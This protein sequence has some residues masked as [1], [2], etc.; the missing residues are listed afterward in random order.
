LDFGGGPADHRAVCF[1][2]TL[3]QKCSDFVVRYNRG[4]I[5]VALYARVS[6]TVLQAGEDKVSIPSQISDSRAKV[7]EA[8]G[9]QVHFLDPYVDDKSYRAGQRM[10]EPSGER[11]DRPAFLRLIADGYSGQYDY[12]GAW[13]EDR[14]YRGVKAA[15]PFGEMLEK[16]GVRVILARE[17]FDM[18]MLYLKAAIGKIELDSIRERTRMGQRGRAQKGLHHGASLTAG[19]EALKDDSG[20]TS[21]RILPEWQTW[22]AGLAEAFLQKLSYHAMTVA[23]PTSPDGQACHWQRL[24]RYVR[25]PFYRGYVRYRGELIPGRQPKMW[26]DAVCVQIETELERRK[27]AYPYTVRMRGQA[28]FTGILRCGLCGEPMIVESNRPNKNHT[29]SYRSYGCATYRRGQPH[30]PNM[31]GEKRVLKLLRMMLS[32]VTADEMYAFIMA[33]GEE[34]PAFVRQRLDQLREELA[35]VEG[36]IDAISSDLERVVSM[37]T[38]KLLDGSLATEQAS[39][40]TLRQ[41]IRDYEAGNN[42][43]ADQIVAQAMRLTGDEAVWDL[44]PPEL[45]QIISEAVPTIYAREGKISLVMGDEEMYVG[46]GRLRPVH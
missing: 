42:L 37:T 46:D 25:N 33:M 45:R 29:G 39:A 21:Y 38:K 30:G 28:I 16:A 34:R 11:A 15:V 19:Y 9:E 23:V 13:K 7:I 10:V 35:Q 26:E 22:F 36:R 40:E 41:R 44:P 24:R 17:T 43:D 18:K 4:M 3:P 32:G 20:H 2:T 14:L 6:L 12:I 31:I 8:L 27:Q 1:F 5:R